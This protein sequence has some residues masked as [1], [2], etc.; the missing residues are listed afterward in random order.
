MLRDDLDGRIEQATDLGLV[1]RA[2]LRQRPGSDAGGDIAVGRGL[3]N[4]IL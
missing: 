2:A 1:V 4:C 3:R